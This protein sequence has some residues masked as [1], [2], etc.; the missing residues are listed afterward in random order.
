M[1]LNNDLESTCLKYYTNIKKECH[2]TE[3]LFKY[4]LFLLQIE[5]YNK[6][7]EFSTIIIIS[8]ALL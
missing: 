5:N 4:S 3:K 1:L 8:L 2:F 7:L 6:I